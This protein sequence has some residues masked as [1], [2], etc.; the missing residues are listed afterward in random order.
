MYFKKRHEL[1]AEPCAVLVVVINVV[2]EYLACVL[3]EPLAFA[4]MQHRGKTADG[5]VLNRT[6]VSITLADYLEI[7]TVLV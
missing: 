6:I 3:V 2:A 1:C 7:L 5:H 4:H